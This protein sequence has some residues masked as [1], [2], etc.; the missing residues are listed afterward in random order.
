LNFDEDGHLPGSVTSLAGKAELVRLDDPA[1]NAEARPD[2]LDA[3]VTPIERFFVRNNGVLPPDLDLS[4]WS[5]TIDGCV[6]KPLQLTLM[7]LKAEFETVCLTAVLECAGN[8]R[9]LFTPPAEGLQWGLGA[10]GCAVLTGVR[11][12]DVLRQAGVSPDTV[13]IGHQSPD[14]ALDGSGRAALSRGLPI[15]KAMA[16]ETLLAFEMNG[17]P[18]PLLH[19]GPLR[20]VAP[21]FPGSAWQKWLTRLWVRDREHDGEKMTG[22]TYRLPT[23]SVMPGDMKPNVAFAVI[24]DMPP[25][26]MITWP[27]PGFMAASGTLPVRGFAWSGHTALDHV[28]ISADGGLNWLRA[29]LAPRI[30]RFAWRRFTADLRLPAGDVELLAR[31]TDAEGRAQPLGQADWNPRGYCNNGVHRVCGTILD[32]DDTRAV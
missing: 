19:G 29:E 23:S 4:A 17:T 3:E 11:M 32:Q 20:V 7:Q 25:R 13:Y 15:A 2:L 31:A 24:V 22:S 5:L 8:G 1:L 26:A 16:D 28:D 18:L 30:E 27:V 14:V 21:G 10:V 12:A 9:A 6:A